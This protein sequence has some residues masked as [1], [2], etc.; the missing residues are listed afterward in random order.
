MFS[1]KNPGQE[2][3]VFLIH[4]TDWFSD[5]QSWMEFSIGICIKGAVRISTCGIKR[6]EMGEGRGKNQAGALAR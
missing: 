4:A 5:M 1:N 6:E 3:N 2:L